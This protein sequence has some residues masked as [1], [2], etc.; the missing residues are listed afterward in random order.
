MQY[1]ISKKLVFAFGLIFIFFTI[2]YPQNKDINSSIDEKEIPLLS[3]N[4]DTILFKFNNEF[5]I[6]SF[7][8]TYCSHC[9]A[10]LNSLEKNYEKWKTEF[11]LEIIAVAGKTDIVDFNKIQKFAKRKSYSYSL[12]IDITNKFAEYIFN[13]KDVKKEENFRLFNG[14]I[15][16]LKPQM[17]IF[18]S[19]GN[20]IMQKRAFLV[21]DEQK[22]YEFLKNHHSKQ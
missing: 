14:K 18:D 9:I 8:S 2:V 6:V 19:S 5:T 15:D 21:G 3:L 13:S 22:I 16:V 20:I 11:N 1:S 17:F 7:F 12:Y 4:T 10:E